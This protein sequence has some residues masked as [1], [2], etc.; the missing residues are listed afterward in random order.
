MTYHLD[1]NSP[2]HYFSPTEC[3]ACDEGTRTAPKDPARAYRVLDLILAHPEHHDQDLYYD[4]RS[5]T[6]NES[7]H[8][9][10]D[11]G[12]FLTGCGTT[13]CAAGWTLL[14]AGYQINDLTQVIKP[15]GHEVHRS[16]EIEAA[17]LL[18]LTYN[19]RRRLFHEFDDSKV[20]EVIS[21][22]FGPRSLEEVSV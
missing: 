13:A 9:Y 5:A 2:N 15:N 18:G 16:L 12:Y 21:E 19:E 4:D 6:S 10:H 1:H 17:D 8:E 3:E 11:L 20:P 7:R 22:I 14:E